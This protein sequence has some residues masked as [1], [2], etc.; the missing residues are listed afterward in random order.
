MKAKIDRQWNRDVEGQIKN[1]APV[2]KWLARWIGNKDTDWESQ[3]SA[4]QKAKTVSGTNS[5]R[6]KMGPV[7][8]SY[9]DRA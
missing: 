9:N 4:H 8:Q 7:S 3:K 1:L 2:K 5:E 6:R